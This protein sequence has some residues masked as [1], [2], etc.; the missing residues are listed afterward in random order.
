MWIFT[1]CCRFPVSSKNLGM[2]GHM[3]SGLLVLH[4]FHVP[5]HFRYQT[6]VV[7]EQRDGEPAPEAPWLGDQSAQPW[8]EGVGSSGV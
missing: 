7:Y 3:R 8:G 1:Y 6:G 2:R 4:R 5:S